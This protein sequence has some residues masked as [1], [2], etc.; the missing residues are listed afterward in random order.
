MNINKIY[1]SVLSG[2]EIIRGGLHYYLTDKDFAI[3]LNNKWT[4]YIEGNQMFI[5]T[6]HR[7]FMKIDRRK[8]YR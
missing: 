2:S 6:H 3:V 7:T 5:G 4:L 1:K 8:K